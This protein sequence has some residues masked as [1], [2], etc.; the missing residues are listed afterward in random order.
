MRGIAKHAGKYILLFLLLV[1]FGHILSSG[2]TIS[3]YGTPVIYYLNE[4]SYTLE[5]VKEMKE[6]DEELENYL[7]FT[8]CGS[9]KEQTFSNPDLGKSL[10]SDTVYIYGSSSL[11][12]QADGELLDDDLSGCILSSDAAWQLFGETSVI[13]GEV[14]YQNKTYYV[15]GVYENDESVVILPAQSIFAQNA[16]DSADDETSDDSSDAAFDKIIIKPELEDAKRSEYIQA[17]ENRWSL[18]TKTDCLIYQ[19]LTVFFMMLIPAIIFLYVMFRGLH[20]IIDNRYKPFWII[21]G[22]FGM[23]IMFVGFFVVCQ[24]SPSIPADLIPNTWSDFDFWSDTINTFKTSIQH[25]LFMSKSDIELSY[26]EPLTGIIGYTVIEVI[27][28][29]ITLI[30]FKDSSFSQT[31]LTLIGTAVTEI[32]V[33]WFLRQSDLVL[34]SKQ[35]LLYLWPYL[36]IG[37]NIFKNSKKQLTQK[38]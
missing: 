37:K 14:V 21:G 25:I 35:M 3:G 28:F 18:Y 30:C 17:F 5:Q 32:I 10:T 1:C 34:G 2:T 27:L 9:L 8:A 11:I 4:S 29:F 19:R 12:C 7:P 22:I 26:F 33:I 36:L 38:N 13:G 24:V 20:F 31:I 6:N 15:R 16:S 23:A